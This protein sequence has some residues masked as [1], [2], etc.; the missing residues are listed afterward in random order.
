MSAQLI[1]FRAI[2]LVRG[3]LEALAMA[4]FAAMVFIVLAPGILVISFSPRCV[5]SICLYYTL[6]DSVSRE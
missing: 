2:F 6:W 3:F 1:H 5:L 4:L